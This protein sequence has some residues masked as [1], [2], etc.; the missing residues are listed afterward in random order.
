[1]SK[2]SSSKKTKDVKKKSE[3]KVSNF[4]KELYVKIG[5]GIAIVVVLIVIVFCFVKKDDNENNNNTNNTD[6]GQVAEENIRVE[7]IKPI[8]KEETP[9]KVHNIEDEEVNKVES[10]TVKPKQ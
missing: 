1:M 4:K 8:T 6:N 10:D 9:V 2:T 5:I 3:K 7:D